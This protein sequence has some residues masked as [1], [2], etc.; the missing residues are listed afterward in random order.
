MEAAIMYGEHINS[1]MFV[2]VYE[3]IAKN[4]D[5][6]VLFGDNASWHSSHLT[7]KF[8]SDRNT[9]MIF[10]LPYSPTLNPI[11]VVFL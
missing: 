5:D 4:G 7:T 11:E 9:K 10:N 6:F 1:K 2:E 3:E 8:L